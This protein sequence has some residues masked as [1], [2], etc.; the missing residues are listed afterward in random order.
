MSRIVA[1]TEGAAA[2]AVPHA[3]PA[4]AAAVAVVH[5]PPAVT[6]ARMLASLQGVHSSP[7]RIPGFGHSI[8]SLSSGG[9]L[10]RRMKKRRERRGVG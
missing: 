5:A 10:Y 3:A 1:A 7:R 2:A 9:I 6:V 8:F 4:L